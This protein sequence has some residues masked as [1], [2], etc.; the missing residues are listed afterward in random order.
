MK[1][2]ARASRW[3][4]MA[5]E[6]FRPPHGP[7][8]PSNAQLRR[9]SHDFAATLLRALLHD[10][11]VSFQA[12]KT[13]KASI[14]PDHDAKTARVLELYAIADGVTVPGPGGPTAVF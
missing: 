9:S 2:R 13:F 6:T 3:W 7:C 4:S 10:E 12:V 1:A 8:P 11:G 5:S 14:D